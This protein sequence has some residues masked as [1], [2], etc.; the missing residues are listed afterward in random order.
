MKIKLCNLIFSFLFLTFSLIQAQEIEWANRIIKY[1]TQYGEKTIWCYTSIRSAKFIT[2]WEKAQL[3]GN[4]LY[5]I[6]E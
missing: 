5:L 3:P 2:I 4:L 1:S 6:E